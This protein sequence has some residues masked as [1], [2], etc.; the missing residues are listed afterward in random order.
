MSYND[1]FEARNGQNAGAS[2]K[3]TIDEN[4][5]PKRRRTKSAKA[6][7]MEYKRANPAILASL[8]HV[9]DHTL[10]NFK[11]LLNYSL[12]GQIKKLFHS[13]KELTRYYLSSCLV[14]ARVSKPFEID[15]RPLLELELVFCLPDCPSSLVLPIESHRLFHSL[16]THHNGN[17]LIVI[18]TTPISQIGVPSE[19]PFFTIYDRQR[20]RLGLNSPLPIECGQAEPCHHE[21]KFRLL[22]YF[23]NDL[24]IP[25]DLVDLFVPQHFLRMDL[26]RHVRNRQ[27]LD[28][29]RQ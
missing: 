24:G 23:N 6:I 11:F 22:S 17:T 1:Q 21:K 4:N 12:L 2:M 20:F 14:E 16:F 25:I 13:H 7:Y 26:E 18:F 29:L 19:N 9:R 3:R 15:W 10:T 5:E 27:S 28:A 8:S